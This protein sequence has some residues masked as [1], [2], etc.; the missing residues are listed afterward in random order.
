MALVE[1][2]QVMVIPTKDETSTQPFFIN[3]IF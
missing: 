3:N 1:D 2:R